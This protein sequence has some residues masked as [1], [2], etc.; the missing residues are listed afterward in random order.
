M[1]GLLYAI[2]TATTSIGGYTMPPK[3]WI[4]ASSY[5]LVQLIATF[6]LVCQSGHTPVIPAI[7]I[8]ILF[9]AILITWKDCENIQEKIGSTTESYSNPRYYDGAQIVAT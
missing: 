8:S 6:I 1:S 5:P 7:I 4:K 3:A 9:L 2:G